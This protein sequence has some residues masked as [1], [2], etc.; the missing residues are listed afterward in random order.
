MHVFSTEVAPVWHAGAMPAGAR[1]VSNDSALWAHAAVCT[2]PTGLATF[3]QRHQQRRAA[4]AAAMAVAA[5]EAGMQRQQ[6][7]ALP[8]AGDHVQIDL[9]GDD[10]VEL[11]MAARPNP[12]EAGCSARQNRLPQREQQERRQAGGADSLQALQIEALREELAVAEAVVADLKKHL[13]DAERAIGL[14]S[15]H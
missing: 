7:A 13:R 4:C 12:G 1:Q 11:A 8:A 15:L 2:R 10:P 14:R 9:T 5:A 3:Q 6:L